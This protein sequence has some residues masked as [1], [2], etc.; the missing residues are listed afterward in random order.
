MAFHEVRITT[1]LGKH[2]CVPGFAILL[3][4]NAGLRSPLD[5]ISKPSALGCIGKHSWL[6]HWW[7]WDPIVA[8]RV[9]G[10]EGEY[11]SLPP[12]SPRMEG[13]GLQP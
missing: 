1:G 9:L 7:G 4:P 10:W 6:G 13:P 5:C 2:V 8:C 12:R 11:P 3:E